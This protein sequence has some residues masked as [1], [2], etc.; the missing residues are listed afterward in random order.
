[1]KMSEKV[2]NL[3]GKEVNRRVLVVI[4]GIAWAATQ[5]FGKERPDAGIA[6]RAA[7]KN[8]AHCWAR[9]IRACPCN[10]PMTVAVFRVSVGA[11]LC[12]ACSQDR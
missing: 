4:A 9:G 12:E 6:R 1:L 3:A 11:V 8:R 7:F 5:S 10:R 2:R